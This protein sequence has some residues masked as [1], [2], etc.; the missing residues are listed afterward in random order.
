MSE[1]G[2][3]YHIT[4]WCFNGCQVVDRFPALRLLHLVLVRLVGVAALRSAFWAWVPIVALDTIRFVR[5][6]P[7]GC[8]SL[9]T[10]RA[11]RRRASWLK[12]LRPFCAAWHCYVFHSDRPH[13]RW[14]P[15]HYCTIQWRA[16][17]SRIDRS[18]WSSP[19]EAPSAIV[20]P[21][22]ILNRSTYGCRY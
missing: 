4:F 21:L 17:R 14:G 9:A 11:A 1:T 22:K 10:L 18:D 20:W 15:F 8:L 16:P 7:A 3:Y 13:S 2:K 5:G 6:D 12:C 19:K